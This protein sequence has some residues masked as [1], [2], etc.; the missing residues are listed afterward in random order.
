ML[1]A[2]LMKNKVECISPEETA[3]AAAS[4]MRDQ[5]VG[6]LPVCDN[7]LKVIGTLTDRDIAMRVVAAGRSPSTPVSQVMTHEV[8]GCRESDDVR[9]AEE[10]MGLY[11]KSRIVC[12]DEADVLVGVISLSDIA[13]HESNPR[14][15]QTM[16]E[17]TG[18]E[19][20]P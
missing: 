16:R 9:R 14:L 20:R 15:A 19:V 1:C 12:L 11:Q 8:V 17:V 5:N 6:F 4:R 13:Q 3:E 10:L 7:T 2:E 18:R